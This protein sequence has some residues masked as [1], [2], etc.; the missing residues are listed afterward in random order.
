MVAH[1]HA[2][3]FYDAD[4]RGLIANVVSHLTEAYN[5]GSSLCVLATQAH[6]EAI[7]AGLEAS[8]V[9]TQRAIDDGRYMCVDAEATLRKFMVHGYPDAVLFDA[10]CGEQTRALVAR[11]QGR[12]LCGYGEM[13]DLLWR[14]EKTAAAVRL[15]QLW[16]ELRAKVGRFALLCS[17]RID[18]FGREFHSGAIDSVLRTHSSVIPW[19]NDDRLQQSVSTAMAHVLGVDRTAQILPEI[20]SGTPRNWAA[21]PR[22]ETMILQLRNALPE[23]AGDVLALARDYYEYEVG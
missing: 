6:R 13:V 14:D 2:V 21:V 17:Y 19:G 12:G 11:S 1:E 7:G 23:R 10:T 18:I 8:G 20:T 16:E 4:E 22:G 5:N 15:E 9:D 3:Q